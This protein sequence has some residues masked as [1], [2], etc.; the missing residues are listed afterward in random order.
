MS[1]PNPP[2]RKGFNK[3]YTHFVIEVHVAKDQNNQVFSFHKLQHEQDEATCVRLP[4]QGLEET[5]FALLTE[6]IRK[7]AL[8]ETLVLVSNDE[9]FQERLLS[10]EEIDDDLVQTVTEATKDVLVKALDK[11][12]VLAVQESLQTVKQGMMEDQSS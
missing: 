9:E 11:Q 2:W 7:E 10:G 12:V 6:T 4:H 3:D 8:L 1:V 5:V